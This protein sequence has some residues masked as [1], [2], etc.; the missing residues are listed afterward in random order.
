MV[1]AF[2]ISIPGMFMSENRKIPIIHA[3]LVVL[4]AVFTLGVGLAIWFDTL[5]TKKNLAPLWNQQ[6]SAVL[7][8]LQQKFQ[9][10]G[11]QDATRFV[12]DATCP[13]AADAARHGLCIGP[14]GAF[15][16]S[17]LDIVF[18]AMF[19]VCAV[20]GFLVLSVLCVLKERGEQA[21]YKRIDEKHGYGRG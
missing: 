12:T 18:T 3:W 4:S 15:A 20:D 7:S 13:N 8:L 11:Y 2:L 21:R 17:F 10:C 6:S 1:L 9:C 5:Q 14:F 19:G 16:N